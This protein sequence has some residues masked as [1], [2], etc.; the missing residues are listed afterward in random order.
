MVLESLLGTQT[1]PTPPGMDEVPG[2]EANLVCRRPVVTFSKANIQLSTMLTALIQQMTKLGLQINFGKSR[3]EPAQVVEYLG[4]T[5][6][7]VQQDA[8]NQ[9]MEKVVKTITGY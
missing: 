6:D 2:L 8:S 1:V 5:I 3:L 7:L 9:N 4:Q